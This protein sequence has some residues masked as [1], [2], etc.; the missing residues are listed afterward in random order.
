[1]MDYKVYRD[2]KGNRIFFNRYDKKIDNYS[3]RELKRRL[4]ANIKWNVFLHLT[5]S[6]EFVDTAKANDIRLF[7]NRLKQFNRNRTRE[8]AKYNRWWK[9]HEYYQNRNKDFKYC[10][11]VEFDSSGERDYNPHFHMLIESPFWLSQQKIEKW[12]SR[13]DKETKETNQIGFIN[14]ATIDNPK[15]AKRYVN[16]YMSKNTKGNKWNGRHWGHS[17]NLPKGKKNWKFE[18]LANEFTV[19]KISYHQKELLDG[20]YIQHYAKKIRKVKYVP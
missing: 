16:K 20:H 17:R 19:G 4:K 2:N 7:M 11:K 5:Y 14:M 6:N 13:K 3:L 12:W 15:K 8:Y 10:W 18:G 9:I 1:M